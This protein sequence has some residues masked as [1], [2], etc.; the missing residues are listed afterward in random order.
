MPLNLAELGKLYTI[1]RIGGQEK[2]RH[3]LEKFRTY[4]RAG[5]QTYIRISRIL[6]SQCE[7]RP[8]WHRKTSGSEGHS[9][10]LAIHI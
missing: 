7:G 5:A 3:H 9:R 10:G 1:H 4:T 2:E 6:Y 8:D